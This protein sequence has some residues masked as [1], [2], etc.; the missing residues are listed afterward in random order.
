RD[1]EFV[2]ANTLTKLLNFF[3]RSSYAAKVVLEFTVY[4]CELQLPQEKFLSGN[5]CP[6]GDD[7]VTAAHLEMI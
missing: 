7:L 4:E 3:N 2:R 1:H 6:S 5:C